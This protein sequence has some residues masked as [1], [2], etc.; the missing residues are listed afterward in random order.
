MEEQIGS[1]GLGFC[2]SQAQAAT[3]P[4]STAWKISSLITLPDMRGEILEVGYLFQRYNSSYGIS[5][6]LY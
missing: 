2:F 5:V 4:T 3:A 1:G 6:R